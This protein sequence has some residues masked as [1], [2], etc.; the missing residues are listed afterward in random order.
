MPG[1]GEIRFAHP[2][3]DDVVHGGDDIEEIADAGPA[4]SAPQLVG[5]NPADFE[6]PESSWMD[7]LLGGVRALFSFFVGS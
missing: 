2:Q 7:K 1:R 5:M 6:G 3:A 4:D